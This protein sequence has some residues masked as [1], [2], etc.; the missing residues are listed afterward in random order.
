M[1]C[2]DC[3]AYWFAPIKSLVKV[4]IILLVALVEFVFCQVLG[5]FAVGWWNLFALFIGLF[6][7]GLV[8]ASVFYYKPKEFLI[9]FTLY[10]IATLVVSI[11]YISVAVGEVMTVCKEVENSYGQSRPDPPPFF[12]KRT[13]DLGGHSVSQ[14]L[15]CLPTYNKPE[16]VLVIVGLSITAVLDIFVALMFFRYYRHL[17]QPHS[18]PIVAQTNQ[19]FS[20]VCRQESAEPMCESAYEEVRASPLDYSLPP[21]YPH[22]GRAK[23]E[24]EA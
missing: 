4:R 3:C 18:S 5:F 7:Y 21:T 17:R 19:L 14:V 20:P 10:K 16:K 24:F 9:V 1:I 11:V 6:I 12:A 23:N 22:I 15:N 8:T 2:R 13:A